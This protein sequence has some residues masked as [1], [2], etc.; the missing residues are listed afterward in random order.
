VLRTQPI[1][2][3][4]L[5][6]VFLTRSTGKL[7]AVAKGAR[8]SRRRFGA[9]LMLL[10]RV[11][12]SCF[13]KEGQDLAR[14]E[15]ADLLES[16]YDLQADPARGAVLACFAEVADAFAREQQE[17]EAFYRLLH[18]VLRAVRDGLEL[19]WAARYFE[20]WTFRLHGFLPALDVCGVCGASLAARGGH[21]LRREGIATCGRCGERRAGDPALTPD[22]LKAAGEIVR[23][24]PAALIG[25]PAVPAALAPLAA[26][27]Q[28]LFHDLVERRFRSYEV[29]EQVRRGLS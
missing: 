8:R 24:P 11:R 13:E 19:E 20:I 26:L 4:D 6:V 2:E 1:G 29:L 15:S 5:I 10:S 21:F 16:F 25:V 3:S 7:S 14:L 27:A 28:A 9:N 18:A 17:D 22:A 12:L 23:R